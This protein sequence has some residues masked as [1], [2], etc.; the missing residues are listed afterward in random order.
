MSRK[1][2]FLQTS[3]IMIRNLWF[4]NVLQTNVGNNE[5]Q[6]QQP[7]RSVANGMEIK[8]NKIMERRRRGGT[9]RID[10]R[11]VLV[12]EVENVEDWKCIR[13][14][15]GNEIE[16]R[17]RKRK[18]MRTPQRMHLKQPE[19]TS[20]KFYHIYYS[21]KSKTSQLRTAFFQTTKNKNMWLG[22]QLLV[23]SKLCK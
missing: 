22:E 4:E 17:T 21:S 16:R 18:E 10:T 8:W 20:A 1:A 5:V 12:I 7:K 3:D 19:E 13:K 2:C 11:R 9:V 6:Y 15:T 14:P 23:S